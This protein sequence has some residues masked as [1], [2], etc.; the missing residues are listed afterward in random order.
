MILVVTYRPRRGFALP[1]TLFM[2]DATSEDASAA[3]D[4]LERRSRKPFTLTGRVE[5]V[6]PER[7]H[8]I[9][10]GAVRSVAIFEDPSC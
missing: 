4:A 5:A 6:G 9:K 7:E 10:P 2:Q 1:L 3:Y 8:V